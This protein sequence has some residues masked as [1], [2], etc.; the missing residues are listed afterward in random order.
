MA[1]GAGE[2]AGRAFSRCT[3][4][5]GGVCNH[6]W[7]LGWPGSINQSMHPLPPGQPQTT[8]H[9]QRTVNMAMHER[10][11]WARRVSTTAIKIS[12]C[13]YAGP[14]GRALEN[15]TLQTHDGFCVLHLS[16]VHDQI[17][18]GRAAGSVLRGPP[19]Q[20]A[21]PPLPQSIHPSPAMCIRFNSGYR[22][23]ARP[24]P[25]DLRALSLSQ[26]SIAMRCTHRTV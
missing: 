25:E 14:W 24:Q 11:E 20:P 5:F 6:S 13:W 26:C 8:A 15:S 23:P 18:F 7:R 3:R 19:G 2:A 17:V 10:Q 4:R 1:A 16:Y 12:Q 22:I 21:S 9:A